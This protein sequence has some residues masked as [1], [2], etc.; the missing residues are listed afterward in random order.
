MVQVMLVRDA[1]TSNARN[2]PKLRN[3][4]AFT[5]VQSLSLWCAMTFHTGCCGA[6]V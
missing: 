6:E 3:I 5:L 4:L 2:A 1:A